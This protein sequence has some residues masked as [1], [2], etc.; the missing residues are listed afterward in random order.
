MCI[1]VN[2]H[3]HSSFLA[4]SHL[5][6]QALATSSLAPSPSPTSHI[7]TNDALT[8]LIW[9]TLCELRGRPLPGESAPGCEEHALGLAVDLRRCVAL[10]IQYVQYAHFSWIDSLCLPCT[11]T[12][13]DALQT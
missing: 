11:V 2:G 12:E 9:V 5:A 6:P 7:S 4:E 8:A 13:M 10:L 1:L 3:T